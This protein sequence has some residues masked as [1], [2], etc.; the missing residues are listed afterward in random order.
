[1][2]ASLLLGLGLMLTAS[3]IVTSPAHGQGDDLQTALQMRFQAL[4]R[5]VDTSTPA[6]LDR[7]AEEHLSPELRTHSAALRRQLDGIRKACRSAGGIMVEPGGAAGVTMTFEHDDRIQSVLLE[8]EPTSPFRI[9]KLELKRASTP[10]KGPEVAPM[11][12]ESL[13]QRLEEEEAKGF[14]GSIIAVHNGSIVL[15]RGFGWADRERKIENTKDTIF[16]IGSTPIDFT[17]AAILLLA[18]RGQLKTSDPITKYFDSVP[19]DKRGIRLDQ[20]MTGK[21]GLKNFPGIHGVDVDLD[22]SWLDRAAFLDRI[23]GSEL[24]FAPGSGNAHSHAAWGVLTAIIEIVSGQE[25]HDF[26]REH[27]FEPAGM[28]RTGSYSFTHEFNPDELAVGYGPNRIRPTNS[29]VHWGKTSWL[30]KGS[31]GMVST[32]TDLYHWNRAVRGG[33]LLSPESTKRYAGKG[34]GMAAGGNDRGFF[35]LYNTGIDTIVIVCSNSHEKPRD[36]AGQVS[37]TAVRLAMQR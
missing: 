34:E 17:H 10:A 29:P 5:F 19:A 35:T 9:T 33:Q 27:L 20:L 12:W 23:L 36:H 3:L 26:L 18:D 6:A 28:T 30:V 4:E 13:E 22:L 11:T 16:A 7:F 32:P 15:Q 37:M 31:G 24:L 8:L 1:M 14:S 21:S 2:K 25:Y